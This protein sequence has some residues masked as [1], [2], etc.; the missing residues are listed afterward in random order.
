MAGRNRTLAGKHP[1]ECNMIRCHWI[2]WYPM[3][4][5]FAW[6]MSMAFSSV[7]WQNAPERFTGCKAVFEARSRWPGNAA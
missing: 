1:R 4:G 7:A 2:A 5:R 3:R 6:A